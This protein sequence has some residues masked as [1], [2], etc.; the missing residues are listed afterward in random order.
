LRE[1]LKNSKAACT[2]AFW[3]RPLF[4]SGHHRNATEVRAFWRDL[5][6]EHADVVLNG[7]AHQYERFAPQ[8]ADGLADRERWL[9]QFVV[10]TGGKNLI[11]FWRQQANSLVR[12]SKSYGVLKLELRAKSFAWG[13]VSEEGK[14]LDS[15]EKQCHGK[16]Q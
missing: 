9:T 16:P 8:T 15:G 13:F 4:T 6:N 10:G 11:R 2:L 12:L 7:H 5:Y 1:D 3:H 14:V